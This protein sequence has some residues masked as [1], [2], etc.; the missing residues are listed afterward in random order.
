MRPRFSLRTLLLFVLLIGS[1]AL[2]WWDWGPWTPAYTVT[3]DGELA[4]VGFAQAGR[5]INSYVAKKRPDGDYDGRFEYYQF[6]TGKRSRAPLEKLPGISDDDLS[7]A[8]T[9]YSNTGRYIALRFPRKSAS[10]LYD[11]VTAQL[12]PFPRYLSHYS[13]FDPTDQWLLS[14]SPDH[15]CWLFHVPDC[16]LVFEDPVPKNAKQVLA[17]GDH[18]AV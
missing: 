8:W 3:E 7:D 9:W 6:A 4:N 18:F 17:H 14:T 13:Y 11:T 15:R 1:G 5:Y 16:S 2:L 10:Y 12:T